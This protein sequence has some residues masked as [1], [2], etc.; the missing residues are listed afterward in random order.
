LAIAAL[1]AAFVCAPSFGWAE[2]TGA[3]ST[4]VGDS[5]ARR[6][7]VPAPVESSRGEAADY[8]AREAAAPALAS[9]AGGGG[10][11]YIGGGALVVV[12]LVV[13]IVIL[14]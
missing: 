5:I 7:V 4:D 1:L 10:G 9:F 6:P 12:L 3:R 2:T 8:A 13:I 11:I 14:L